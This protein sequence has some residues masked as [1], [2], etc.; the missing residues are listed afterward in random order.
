[1]YAAAFSP[2]VW[3][4]RMPSF[5][6]SIRVRGPKNGMKNTWVM[7]YPRVISATKRAP[8][9]VAMMRPTLPEARRSWQTAGGPGGRRLLD[10]G[11]AAGYAAEP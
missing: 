11:P 8:V 4:R 7:P 1:M 6:I 9:I 5:S 3:M 2:W 10:T